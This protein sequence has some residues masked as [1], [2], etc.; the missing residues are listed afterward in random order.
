M[1]ATVATSPISRSPR[2][3]VWP[4]FQPTGDIDGITVHAD[5]TDIDADDVL[6]SSVVVIG[7]DAFDDAEIDAT[8]G[9][10]T[11]VDVVSANTANLN[12]TANITNSSIDA[13]ARIN[14]GTDN[15]AINITGN[16]IEGGTGG[17]IDINATELVAGNTVNSNN[18]T[19]TSIT[20]DAR[21]LNGNVVTSDGS[22]TLDANGTATTAFVTANEVDAAFDITIESDGSIVS[23]NLPGWR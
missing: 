19:A 5:D 3:P 12:A 17:I 1:R 7:T 18:V 8:D 16:T 2:T 23:V 22:V 21:I 14:I 10:I 6:N 4:I 9:S 20:I 13:F 15:T 11:A